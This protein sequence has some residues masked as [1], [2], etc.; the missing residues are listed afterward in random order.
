MVTDVA[1]H[2]AACSRILRF[3]ADPFRADIGIIAVDGALVNPVFT[4]HRH[5]DVR[6][7]KK[8]TG[9]LLRATRQEEGTQVPAS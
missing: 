7:C 8:K 2:P 3:V 5:G 1:F 6:A 4:V 9:R